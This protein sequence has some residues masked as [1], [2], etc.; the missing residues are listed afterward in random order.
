MWNDRSQNVKCAV[1]VHVEHTRERGVV[2]IGNELPSGESTDRVGEQINLSE[3]RDDRLGRLLSVVQ[4]VQSCG[5]SSEVRMIEIMRF[6]LGSKA[7][8]QESSIEQGFCD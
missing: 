1:D 2:S 5:K 7:R 3:M 8:H 4:A 6:D